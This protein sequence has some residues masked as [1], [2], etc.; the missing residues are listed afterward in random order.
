MQTL[1]VDDDPLV[2]ELIVQ[3]VERIGQA[4]HFLSAEDALS[5][6]Q[7]GQYDIAILDL[8]LGGMP[9]NILAERLKQ[10]DPDLP[11]ICITGFILDDVHPKA[12]IFDAI[13]KKPFGIEIIDVIKRLA[14]DREN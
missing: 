6:F 4:T 1:I 14:R 10:A 8:G 9:G 12:A 3:F 7:P 5:D 13:I 2:G 11:C